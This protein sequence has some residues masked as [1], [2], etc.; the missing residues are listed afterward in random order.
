MSTLAD[1]DPNLAPWRDDPHPALAAFRREQPVFRCPA[2]DT[3]V[4]TRYEDV[5]TVLSDG[6]GSPAPRC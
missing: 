6:S 5:A 3:W 1:F 2:Q 4:V